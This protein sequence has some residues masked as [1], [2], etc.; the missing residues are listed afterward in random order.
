MNTSAESCIVMYN[1]C[2][3]AA[4][5]TSLCVPVL[6]CVCVAAAW[7][8]CTRGRACSQRAAPAHTDRRLLLAEN[9]I[10]SAS[11]R[12]ANADN[13]NAGGAASLIANSSS[14][15]GAAAAT[16][17]Y[18]RR[19]SI[20]LAYRHPPSMRE[21]GAVAPLSWTALAVSLSSSS[22]AL[23]LPLLPT[24]KL[25]H[26]T[27]ARPRSVPFYLI[28]LLCI[29][30]APT[31]RAHH[32]RRSAGAL[33]DSHEALVYHLVLYKSIIGKTPQAARRGA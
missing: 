28:I 9:E 8:A 2:G 14:N 23:Q 3:V 12:G 32:R 16:A 15:C 11:T 33:V 6:L 29:L 18:C 27:C 24:S 13:S 25:E 19:A 26:L 5:F 10:T 31:Q 1:H 21:V 7:R 17:A 4:V 22:E 30:P 20:A